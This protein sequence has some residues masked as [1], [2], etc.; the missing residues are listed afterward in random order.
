M[1]DTGGSG[2]SLEVM[3]EK[4]QLRDF[5]GLTHQV[6]A[7]D[8]VWIA[9]LNFMKREQL[10]PDNHFFEHARWRAW[11]AY[12]QVRRWGVLPPRSTKCT[13][14]NTTMRRV[15]SACWRRRKTPRC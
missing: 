5:L 7:S 14:S 6:Y 15:I 8:P 1:S 9:P 13:C 11:M 2:I 3:T 10:S 4:G 12:R